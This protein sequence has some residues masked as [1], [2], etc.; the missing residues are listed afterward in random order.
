MKKTILL[1]LV[2][3]TGAMQINA[4]PDEKTEGE[5]FMDHLR[6]NWDDIHDVIMR[7][8][9]EDPWLKGKVVINMTWTQGRLTAGDIMENTTANESYAKDLVI[10]MESWMIDELPGEWSSALPIKTSIK[11]SEDPD[12]AEYGILTGKLTDMDG[13]PIPE[14]GLVLTASNR[15]SLKS[16][17]LHTNR[18]GIF[19]ETLIPPGTYSLSCNVKGYKPLTIEQ[20]VIEKGMHCKKDIQMN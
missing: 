10:V 15:T 8:H 17:A 1:L 5:I 18:E 16:I 20:I 9:Y 13:T 3:F 6:K 4:Q 19:I 11:G 14:S 12:F 2:L 7:Y